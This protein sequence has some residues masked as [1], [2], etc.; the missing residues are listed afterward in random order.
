[1]RVLVFVRGCYS[2]PVVLPLLKSSLV[3]P[4]FPHFH[5]PD[6]S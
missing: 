5:Q 2:E 6:L 1:M 4:T 3:T